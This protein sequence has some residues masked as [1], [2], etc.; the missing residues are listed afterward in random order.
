MIVALRFF[1]YGN[2]KDAKLI[3][4]SDIESQLI[5]I[6]KWVSTSKAAILE[7]CTVRLNWT[8]QSFKF[9]ALKLQNVYPR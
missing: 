1:D 4:N 3:G 2:W 9:C 6:V 5:L 7:D 8:R